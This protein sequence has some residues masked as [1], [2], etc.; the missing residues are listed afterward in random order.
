MYIIVTLGYIRD[1]IN[2]YIGLNMPHI[3]D[4]FKER[5]IQPVSKARFIH[6]LR[7]FSENA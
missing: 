6:N 3:S 4:I 7:Y 2:K 1:S 5:D